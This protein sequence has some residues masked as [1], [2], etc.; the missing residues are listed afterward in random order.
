MRRAA[1]ALAAFGVAFAL[2]GCGGAGRGASAGGA[3]AGRERMARTGTRPV[4]VGEVAHVRGPDV[5][6]A[7]EPLLRAHSAQGG[8]AKGLPHQ[9]M[10][11]P[12]RVGESEPGATDPLTFDGAAQNLLADIRA[13]RPL[14]EGERSF[15]DMKKLEGPASDILQH[16]AEL[17]RI[18]ERRAANAKIAAELAPSAPES[19]EAEEGGGKLRAE[20]AATAEWTA[21]VERVKR[22]AEWL[23]LGALHRSREG[24]S[25]GWASL[26]DSA[27][28]L[29]Q[30]RAAIDAMAVEKARAPAR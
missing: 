24:V 22:A 10:P 12:Y 1:G 5:W 16:A 28:E 3:G 30:I 17:A 20:L 13:A 15:D 8:E 29:P 25:K 27:R 4:P 14:A 6:V 18:M 21:V 7:V 23:L 11:A 19:A 2:A 9:S 26:L